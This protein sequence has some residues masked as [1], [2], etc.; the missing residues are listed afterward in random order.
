[1]TDFLIKNVSR[2]IKTNRKV[3]WTLLRRCPERNTVFWELGRGE[4]VGDFFEEWINIKFAELPHSFEWIFLSR[5]FQKKHSNLIWCYFQLFSGIC[6]RQYGILSLSSEILLSFY[7]PVYNSL[8]DDSNQFLYGIK[9]IQ[10]VI[11]VA[12]DPEASFS[13]KM[14][15]RRL[16]DL[17]SPIPLG[18]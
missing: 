4:Y 9:Y 12:R 6:G 8:R 3:L 10:S 13:A 2:L 16:G 5:K 17:N 18:K 11:F 1:M 7:C 14:V 15:Y